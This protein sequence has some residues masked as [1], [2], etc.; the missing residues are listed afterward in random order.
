[1]S[2]TSPSSAKKSPVSGKRYWHQ[3]IAA[4]AKHHR[5]KEHTEANAL[6]AHKRRRQ[7]MKVMRLG[8][9]LEES[10]YNA[11][12]TCQRIVARIAPDRCSVRGLLERRTAK[13][14][15]E[16]FDKR[17]A[18]SYFSAFLATADRQASTGTPRT[19]S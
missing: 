10:V 3:M 12:L 13:T 17:K 11:V 2:R 19:E 16:K 4:S 9:S 15:T 14:E 1:M 18:K 7:E 6:K 5:V 8:E